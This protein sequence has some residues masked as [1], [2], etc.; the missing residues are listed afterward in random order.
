MGEVYVVNYPCLL[1]FPA[2]TEG[3]GHCG[4]LVDIFEVA[5]GTSTC[6]SSTSVRPGMLCAPSVSRVKKKGGVVE[7]REFARRTQASRAS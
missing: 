5:A 7:G 1:L 4:V 6:S 3:V 2:L